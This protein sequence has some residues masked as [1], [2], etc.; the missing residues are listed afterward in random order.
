MAANLSSLDVPSLMK[1][2]G[3]VPYIITWLRYTGF[4]LLYPTGVVNYPDYSLLDLHAKRLTRVH[5]C[6]LIDFQ[7]LQASWLSFISRCRM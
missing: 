1:E 2:S 7:A 5:A 4:V 3:Y 6:A